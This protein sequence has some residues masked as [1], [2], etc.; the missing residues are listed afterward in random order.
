MSESP[1]EPRRKARVQD[2]WRDDSS[3][4]FSLHGGEEEGDLSSAELDA[5]IARLDR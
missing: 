3:D 2:V 4:G 5:E 1:T